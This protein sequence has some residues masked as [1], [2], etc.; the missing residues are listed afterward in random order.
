VAGGDAVT[1]SDAGN[2]DLDRAVVARGTARSLIAGVFVVVAVA[3]A[4]IWAPL[5]DRSADLRGVITASLVILAVDVA[6]LVAV[7]GLGTRWRHSYP[8][9]GAGRPTGVAVLNVVAVLQLIVGFAAMTLLGAFQSAN[10]LQ[11]FLA[12]MVVSVAVLVLGVSLARHVS[13]VS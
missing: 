1:S 2:P 10:A 9:P 3:V 12:T 13:R 5:L 8:P 6:C 11:V 7:I 4:V